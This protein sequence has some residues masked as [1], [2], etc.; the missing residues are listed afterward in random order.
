MPCT[1][2]KFECKR[3]DQDATGYPDV[4]HVI[5]TR[6]LARMI[7]KVGLQFEELPDEKFDD[8]MGEYTGGAVI[9]GTTG[10]VMEAALR[11]AVYWI[12]KDDVN[13]PVEFKE[14]RGLQGI[15]EATYTVGEIS[16]RVAVASGLA[17]ARELLNKVR[18]GEEHYDF[19]EIMACP[20][21]CINGG[22]QPQVS[23]EIR[24][25]TDYR[26]KRASALYQLDEAAE[27]RKS[28]QN[29]SLN[30]MYEEYLGE[31]GGEKAHHLLHTTYVKRGLYK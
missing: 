6:E 27:N 24:N 31:I 25:F 26:A 17:N 5:T 18:S 10:G 3:D 28:H 7:K 16:V 12:T 19:I 9:F 30:K 8:P 2:K 11:T 29:V 22:G 1:A 4:D 21:G 23:A 15:K 20:G 13:T 14:V